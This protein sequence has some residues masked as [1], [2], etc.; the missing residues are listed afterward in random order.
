MY[1]SIWASYLKKSNNGCSLNV[2]KGESCL[3]VVLF[4]VRSAAKM[5]K[6]IAFWVSCV[7]SGQPTTIAFILESYVMMV[8]VRGSLTSRLPLTQLN[9]SGYTASLRVRVCTGNAQRSSS[10]KVNGEPYGQQR[11]LGC[12][13]QQDKFKLTCVQCAR[14]QAERVEMKPRSLMIHFTSIL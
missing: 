11:W 14:L 6:R 12:N 7:K 5:T 10:G 2:H 4:V 3:L 9:V 8:P 1:L 13:F